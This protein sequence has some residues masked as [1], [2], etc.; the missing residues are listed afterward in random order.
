MCVISRSKG[1]RDLTDV[2]KV[3]VINMGLKLE[4][5]Y[6]TYFNRLSLT[7]IYNKFPDFVLPKNVLKFF[8]EKILK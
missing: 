7:P 6:N 8:N 5:M 4:N 2:E 3:I 1:I